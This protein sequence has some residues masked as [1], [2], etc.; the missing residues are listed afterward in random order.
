MS[1]LSSNISSFPSFITGILIHSDHLCLFYSFSTQPPPFLLQLRV[2][3]REILCRTQCPAIPR[4]ILGSLVPGLHE[5]SGHP[6]PEPSLWRHL[7]H[8]CSEPLMKKPVV[9]S[10]EVVRTKKDAKM[11]VTQVT[12]TETKIGS[13]EPWEEVG[14]GFRWNHTSQPLRPGLQFLAYTYFLFTD[15]R[16]STLKAGLP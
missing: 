3:T 16:A 7:T 6:L 8:L 13:Q 2:W 5:L 1:I 9:S 12:R 11:A 15:I 4:R 10:G 14:K